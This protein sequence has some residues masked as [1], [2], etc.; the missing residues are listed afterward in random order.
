MTEAVQ[1]KSKWSS[2]IDDFLQRHSDLK[3]VDDPEKLEYYRHDLN[4]DLPPFIRDLLL[5]S[6]PDLVV[7][8]TQANH[9]VD[10]FDL[11][12]RNRIPLT[13]R[14]PEPGDTAAPSPPGEAF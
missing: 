14:A 3:F 2:S 7:R 13:V 6:T 10:L 12:R 1:P 5:K 9:I 11:A 8:P 4:V